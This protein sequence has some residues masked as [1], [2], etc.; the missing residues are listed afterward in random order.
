MRIL[1][2]EGHPSTCATL[3]HVLGERGHVTCVA[4]TGLD[5]LRLATADRFDVIL[6]D[7]DL[8]DLGGI[9][10]VK[11]LRAVSDVKI[12]AT[13]EDDGSM[14]EILDAGADDFLV[15][16]YTPE[17]LEDRLHVV[18]DRPEADRTLRVGA[19][20]IDPAS[21][22]AR[23]GDEELELT[24]K[25]FD[26]LA[27]LAGR[28]GQV[29]SKREL[30]AQVWRDPFGRC[31]RT[32]EVHLSWLRQK[33]GESAAEPRYLRTLR[34]VGVKLVDPGPTRPDRHGSGR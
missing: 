1:L 28:A 5:G 8:V 15:E 4:T 27:Y 23:L 7:L 26:V 3:E 24:R 9:A 12:I 11:M 34:G 22:V 25:E 10:M 29:V 18:R 17:Q 13:A 2:I 14:V 16:P 19:L 33:L 21:R 6:L 31:D 32:V 30:A 20:C